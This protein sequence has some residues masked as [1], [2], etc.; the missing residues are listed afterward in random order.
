MELSK[1]RHTGLV[2]VEGVRTLPS[3][4][5]WLQRLPYVA[6]EASLGTSGASG[7]SSTVCVP[8]VDN[9]K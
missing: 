2:D 1:N 3:S 7:E 4:S 6:V 5:A 9:L 8:I